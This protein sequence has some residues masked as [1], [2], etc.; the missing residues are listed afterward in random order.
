[1]KKIKS[2]SKRIMAIMLASLTIFAFACKGDDGEEQKN[3]NLTYPEAY[4][5]TT[6]INYDAQPMR[7]IEQGNTDYCII[8]PERAS[9]DV[10]DS[11][12]ELVSYARDVSGASF[13][14]YTETAALATEGL[15]FISIGNTN[16]ASSA[17]LDASAVQNDGFI[18]K[19]VDANIYILARIDRGVR[20]G[21]YSF[22]E[23]FFGVRWL[24]SSV[25]H[26]PTDTTIDLYPCDIIEEPEF[27]MRKWHSY[28]V[29]Y[30]YNLAFYNHSRTYYGEW[31]NPGREHHNV[32]DYKAYPGVGYL[33]KSDTATCDC[34]THE[35]GILLS[36]AHPEYWTDPTNPSSRGYYDI[37][38][39]NG[40]ADDGTLKDGPSGVRHIID[41][42]KG[43]LSGPDGD[44]YNWFML[45]KMDYRGL[46]CKC[47]TCMKRYGWF[48][49]WPGG[50]G[51]AGVTVMFINCIEHEV[52]SWLKET[53][54]GRTVN[55]ATFAYHDAEEPPV[56]K[57]ADGSY[58]PINELCVA[59][60]NVYMRVAPI[61]ADYAYAISDPRQPKYEY[62]Y[63]MFKGW[64]A[65]SENMLVWDYVSNYLGMGSLMYYPNLSYYKDNL[66]LYKESGVEYVFSEWNGSQRDI[67]H[68]EI[69]SYI[70]NRLYWNLNWDVNYLLNEYLTLFYGE[71]A[72]GVK[73]IIDTYEA[74]YSQMRADGTLS[75]LVSVA[76][77]SFNDTDSYPLEFVEKLFNIIEEQIEEISLN[78]NLTDDEKNSIIA[79]FKGVK[80]SPM[81]IVRSN[82]GQYYPMDT[83]A[84]F[85][86]EFKELCAQ[87]KYTVS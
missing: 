21:V 31:Y 51:F 66:K 25:T 34:D 16:L 53:Q 36:E 76:Q 74:L 35:E 84:E 45:G 82:Y 60:E 58:S 79:R 14:I 28:A 26:V 19:T 18:I 2:I 85:E 48:G 12:K 75:I 69:R 5:Y 17:G 3:L 70:A 47:D 27:M 4:N 11:A 33:N 50:S 43:V 71:A 54:N 68:A 23:R 10:T 29:D 61:D 38:F 1:M 56:V 81:A 37:C 72:D 40:I 42:I 78:E 55:F 46:V 44:Q 32:T 41:K 49:G 83:Q 7:F 77:T 20:Y 73:E 15:K 9:A 64:D 86:K 67:W 39:S 59:N 52:N 24:T 57:N 30:R 8:V 87:F 65:C 63:K 13:T 22:I 62:Y 6:G 80:L